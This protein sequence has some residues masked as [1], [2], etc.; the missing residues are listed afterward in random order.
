MSKS[1]AKS[2]KKWFEEDYSEF[3]RNFMNKNK[4]KSEIVEVKRS[5]N[6]TFTKMKHMTTDELVELYDREEEFR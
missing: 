5:K 2:R 1:I 4:K 3:D 6:R